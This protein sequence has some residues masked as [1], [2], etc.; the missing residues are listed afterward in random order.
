MTDW[1]NYKLGEETGDL[2]LES[3]E[4]NQLAALSLVRQGEATLDIFSRDLEPRIFNT[5]EFS[6][7]V[8]DMALKNKN[9]KVRVL[10]IDPDFAIKHGHSLINLSRRLT[11]YIEVRKV[12]EDYT[13]IPE[14]YLVVDHRG[15]LHRNLASRYEG[16]VNYNLPM[17][18]ADL[19]RT[20]NEIWEKSR[21]YIDF[22][23]LNI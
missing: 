23:Q 9:I 18:A 22:K 7:A 13:S 15:V 1:S 17:R 16:T 4:D 5:L 14:A 2:L 11:S 19:L 21:S 10:V 6:E 20:F 12:H 3:F 8:K